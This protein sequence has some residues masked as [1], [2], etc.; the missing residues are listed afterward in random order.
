VLGDGVEAVGDELGGAV[1]HDRPACAVFGVGVV[2]LEVDP[3]EGS[4]ADQGVGFAADDD[5]V[6]VD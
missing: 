2:D 4:A 1:G 6:T 5:G 3:V